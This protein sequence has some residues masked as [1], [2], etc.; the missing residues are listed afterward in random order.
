MESKRDF[1]AHEIKREII[2]PREIHKMELKAKKIKSDDA[3]NHI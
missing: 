3:A 1:A 2:L